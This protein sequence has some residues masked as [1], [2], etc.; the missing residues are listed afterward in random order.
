MGAPGGVAVIVICVLVLL[1]DSA[2]MVYC[3]RNRKYLPLKSANLINM[4]LTYVSMLLTFIG[5]ANVA[6]FAGNGRQWMVCA[7]AVGWLGMA[8]GGLLFVAMLQ[9]RVYSYVN[10]FVLNRR[11][12]G[13]FALIPAVYMITLS[14]LFGILAFVLPTTS[15]YEYIADTNVCTAHGG[16]YYMGMALMIIQTL[17]LGLLMFKA[18]RM[19]SCFNEYRKM[20]IVC[21]VCFVCGI[22]LI[23]IQHVHFATGQLAVYGA[24]NILFSFIP[25]HV[26]F[27]TILGMPIFR[28]IRQRD[29]YLHAFINTIED[30]GL[31]HVYELASKCPLG[32]IS[33]LSDAG[34][35]RRGTLDSQHSAGSNFSGNEPGPVCSPPLPRLGNARQSG[36]LLSYY[37]STWQPD[38]KVTTT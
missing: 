7:V 29:A 26:Y 30:K 10:A 36:A 18:R 11:A 17:V 6:S 19:E 22:V 37:S 33:D 2:A 3:F 34:K 27:Y 28:S 38:T 25:Q 12:T 24:L 32:E 1:V 15:G 20:L 35:S 5:T 9:M 21:G 14:T 31:A 4:Y 16:I 23:G 8:L 13:V